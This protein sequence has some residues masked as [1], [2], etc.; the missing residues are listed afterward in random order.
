MSLVT[1]Y[2]TFVFGKV[3]QNGTTSTRTLAQKYKV[4]SSTLASVQY[5]HSSHSHK[6]HGLYSDDHTINA[7]VEMCFLQNNDTT[8]NIQRAAIATQ[9][10]TSE[11]FAADTL[12]KNIQSDVRLTVCCCR[13]T[14]Q[15][16]PC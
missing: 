1:S 3:K 13:Y 7:A 9:S 8:D 16:V 6:V 14:V 10:D 4:G 12:S 5:L 11:H 15:T 2:T